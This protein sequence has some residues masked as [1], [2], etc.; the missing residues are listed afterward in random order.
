MNIGERWH[1]KPRRL[2]TTKKIHKKKTPKQRCGVASVT[3]LWGVRTANFFFLFFFYL[4]GIFLG[5]T[6]PRPGDFIQLVDGGSISPLFS[7]GCPT[8]GYIYVIGYVYTCHIIYICAYSNLDILPLGMHIC[9][10]YICS[11]YI[12]TYMYTYIYIPMY[13]QTYILYI[14][15]I[16]IR[17]LYIYIWVY[18]YIHT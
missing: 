12:Y 15:R 2:Q 16:Y 14:W 11:I 6:W 13:I 3:V 17:I 10:T 9:H 4:P 18:I 5:F 7:L 8:I 1:R